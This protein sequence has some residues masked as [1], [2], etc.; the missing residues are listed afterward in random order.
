MTRTN[1][2]IAIAVVTLG[3]ALGTAGSVEANEKTLF[4]DQ[5]PHAPVE[6]NTESIAK[7]RGKD[8]LVISSIETGER[9]HRKAQIAKRPDGN[10][11]RHGR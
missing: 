4:T 3:A 2:R 10:V 7:A 8:G 6:V 5:T 1:S 11:S 9:H